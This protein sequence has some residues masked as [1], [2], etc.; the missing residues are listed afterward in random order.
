MW[1]RNGYT[2]RYYTLQDILSIAKQ[3]GVENMLNNHPEIL[4][5][6]GQIAYPQARV[7]REVTALPEA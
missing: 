4:D 3:E 5:T 6:V 2:N 7:E 1:F